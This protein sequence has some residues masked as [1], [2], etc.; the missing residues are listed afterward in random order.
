[1]HGL[2]TRSR[3]IQDLA[4]PNQQRI[5][6]EGLLQQLAAGPKN[7]LLRDQVMGVAGYI[8]HLQIGTRCLKTVGQFT[9][10]DPGHDDIGEQEV[11][12]P[13]CCCA[14]WRASAPSWAARML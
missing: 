10:T 7:S 3:A 12:R 1:M 5:N 8:E 4:N 6:A 9:S 14:I 11:N 13:L 2:R